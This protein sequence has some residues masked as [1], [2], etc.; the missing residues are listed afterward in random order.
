MVAKGLKA[1]DVLKEL[2]RM[3]KE[4]ELKDDLRWK[5]ANIVVR[6]AEG[7]RYAIVLGK[8]GKEPCRRND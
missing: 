1:R 5:L 8:L 7:K 6:V 3:L 2:R 4:G